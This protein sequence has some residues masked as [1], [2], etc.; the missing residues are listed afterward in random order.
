MKNA[1]QGKN[2]LYQVIFSI[3][4]LGE[5]VKETDFILWFSDVMCYIDTKVYER[6]S[7]ILNTME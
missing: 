3:A 2:I 7:I 4:D 1:G 5:K 6:K